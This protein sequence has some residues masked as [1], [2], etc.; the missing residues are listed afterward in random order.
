MP[1]RLLRYLLTL[2]A[3]LLAVS[4]VGFL[5]FPAQMLAVV[6][7]PASGQSEFL[8]RTLGVPVAMV[9]LLVWVA[10]GAT[11]SPLGRVIVFGL[12]GYLFLSSVVDLW[13]Y[14]QSIVGSASIPS[15]LFRMALGGV[16]LWLAVG[17]RQA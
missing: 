8:L 13:G 16:I 6:G 12:V 14:A 4:A 5:F 17:G 1:E 9:A 2:S 11:R 15:A 10:R 3:I 7:I